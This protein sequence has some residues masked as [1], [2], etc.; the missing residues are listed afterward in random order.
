MIGADA[1][2]ILHLFTGDVGNDGAGPATLARREY[3][4]IGLA[5]VMAWFALPAGPTQCRDQ[6]RR[7]D[8]PAGPVRRGLDC[9]QTAGL[10]PVGDR[11]HINVKQ[12]RGC[13]RTVTA[14]APLAAGTGARCLRAPTGDPISVTDPV[15]FSRGEGIGERTDFQQTVPIAAGTG[16]ARGLSAI[17]R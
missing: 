17:I 8:D 15:D 2:L 7:Q 11:R 3:T 9:L 4:A 14:I 6:L 5:R 10:T 16:Q 13:F 1:D 12:R